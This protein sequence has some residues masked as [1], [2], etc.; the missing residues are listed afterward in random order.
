L[1]DPISRK[2]AVVNGFALAFVAFSLGLVSTSSLLFREGSVHRVAMVGDEERHAVGMRVEAV[3]SFL[4][5]A[6]S[7]LRL[8]ADL[9]GPRM[10]LRSGAESDRIAMIR[11]ALTFLGQRTAYGAVRI[12]G[13]SGMEILRVDREGEELHVATAGELRSTR[14][15]EEVHETSR[16]AG[17]AVFVSDLSPEPAEAGGDLAIRVGLARQEVVGGA[18]RYLFLDVRDTALLGAFDRAHPEP[19]SWSVLLNENGEPLR[20]AMESRAP[21]GSPT[22]VGTESMR[23]FSADWERMASVNVGQFETGDGLFTFA[24]LDPIGSIGVAAGSGGGAAPQDPGRRLR[25]TVVSV[26]PEAAVAVVRNAGLGGVVATDV[27]GVLALGFG[28]WIFAQR[29]L[30]RRAIHARVVGLNRI[31]SSTLGR[32]L[33]REV[34]ARLLRDPSRYAS[35]G[36]ERRRVAVLFADIRGF[37]R[38]SEA[39]APETVVEALNRALSEL[40]SPVLRQRGILDKYTGDGLLA[41]FEPLVEPVDAARRAVTAAREMQ[42]AFARLRREA[43]GGLDELGLGIGISIGDVIMGNVGSEVV[44]NYTVVGDTVN[45]AARLQAVAE[46]GQILL[47][48]DVFVLL[49]PDLRAAS[50]PPLVP[51]GRRRPVAIYRISEP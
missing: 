19:K 32:Y 20:G 30:R 50:M 16:D 35:L 49:Q 47:T 45:V 48:E 25:W 31:L 42:S 3:S 44:M 6:V 10:F 1:P 46:A 9:D 40:T 7:D 11:E 41:F 28:T 21:D 26:L 38:F 15:L 37:T 12:L 36:G 17:E 39:R 14:I 27:F 8:L 43:A 2:R 23:A 33:P 24:H 5:T 22:D 18:T 51:R 4:A 29:V 34:A 13:S